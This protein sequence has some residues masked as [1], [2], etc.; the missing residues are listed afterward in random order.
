M[1]K[2]IYESKGVECPECG[3]V[4]NEL[5]NAKS[6]SGQEVLLCDACKPANDRIK[7][8]RAGR[9]EELTNE[10]K[11]LEKGAVNERTTHRFNAGCRDIGHC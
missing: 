8:V 10:L 11:A 5:F 3:E 9:T 7:L 4:T 1:T 6:K 2:Y